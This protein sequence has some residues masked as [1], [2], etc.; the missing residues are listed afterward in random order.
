MFFFKKKNFKGKLRI[1]R[2]FTQMDLQSTQKDYIIV[3]T[4]NSK[5]KIV[6]HVLYII[7][8]IFLP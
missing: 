1:L 6:L 5:K 7:R 4:K 8:D 3:N 2:F